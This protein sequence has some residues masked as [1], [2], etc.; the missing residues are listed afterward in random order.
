MV[1]PPEN[2][3]QFGS[4]LTVLGEN[5]EQNGKVGNK[6]ITFTHIAIG[7]ANDEYVQPDRAQESLVNELARIPINSVEVHQPTPESVPMLKVEAILP[8]DLNDIVIR[9]FAAV[10]N[11]NN[12]SYLHAVGNCARIYVPKPINNGNVS[13]PVTIEMIFIITSTK[14]IIETDPNVVHASKEWTSKTISQAVEQLI[15]GEVWP[16]DIKLTAKVGDNIT[17]AVSYL[18]NSKEKAIY[19]CS[20]DCVVGKI[21]H[22]DFKSRTAI[23]GGVDV[24]LNIFD[25]SSTI[26]GCNVIK[27]KSGSLIKPDEFGRM[28]VII[29]A[30]NSYF[31]QYTDSKTR[32]IRGWSFSDN[33][34]IV[35][36][37][38]VGGGNDIN[39]TYEKSSVP[40]GFMPEIFH[41]KNTHLVADALLKLHSPG[42]SIKIVCVG[43]SITYGHDE[44]GPDIVQPIA[45]HV[46]PHAQTTYPDAL[47]EYLN[48]T[49]DGGAIVE[50]RGFSGDGT[51]SSYF[52]WNDLPSNADLAVVMLGTNDAGTG[53]NNQSI[54]DFVTWYRKIIEMH[55]SWGQ[56]VILV[57]P[58][59]YRNE[60][61]YK[62]DMYRS[63]VMQLGRAYNCPVIDSELFVSQIDK[64]T[65][66][67]DGVHFH[68]AGYKV[69]AAKICAQLIGNSVLDQNK[70][71]VSTESYSYALQASGRVG[72]Y[73]TVFG[74]SSGSVMF[75]GALA[76]SYGSKDGQAG[77]GTITFVFFAEQDKNDILF[78]GGSEPNNGVGEVLFDYGTEP[79]HSANK[80]GSYGDSVVSNF[81]CSLTSSRGRY[82][83]TIYGRG[84]HSVTIKNTGAPDILTNALRIVNKES[85][86]AEVSTVKGVTI[87]NPSSGTDGSSS[88]SIAI[89]KEMLLDL[90]LYQESVE[91]YWRSSSV[92]LT[93]TSKSS[94]KSNVYMLVPGPN[95]T[96]KHVVISEQAPE[97]VTSVDGNFL[98]NDLTSLVVNLMRPVK[99]N[100]TLLLEL[101]ND[102]PYV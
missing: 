5:A 18:R 2:Q 72:F 46:F 89:N 86:Y 75:N 25:S 8:D 11:F 31:C 1:Q 34:L 37:N 77:G 88:T 42:E 100:I 50:N 101:W 47:Q 10:A 14:P 33:G 38:I 99:N 102:N 57:T 16:V 27:L 28:P 67:S 76:R 66:Y 95:S 68:S 97:L 93:I 23:I 15:H 3:Q 40:T 22:L 83:G 84:W 82:I 56:G 19:S 43:D 4:I 90:G 35:W 39:L 81:D 44:H 62:L 12:Q 73:R 74:E 48:I 6:Q 61:A 78:I 9:E 92:R 7:D 87:H 96:I 91:N 58:T 59:P 52:R 98:K 55:I 29:D 64:D 63:A 41:R 24:I 94:F 30:G 20:P 49:Y 71:I 65:I 32:E 17:T 70:K 54:E 36:T 21:E 85:E 45:P 13:T 26:T 79:T 51:R 53:I 80:Y 69:I 60:T